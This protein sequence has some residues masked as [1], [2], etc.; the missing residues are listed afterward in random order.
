MLGS[1]R[2]ALF[3]PSRQTLREQRDDIQ[4]M[5]LLNQQGLGAISERERWSVRLRPLAISLRERGEAGA[6]KELQDAIEE[7]ERPPRR[8]IT[9]RRE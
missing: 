7:L 2:R 1:I 5:R 6:A 9:G 8:Q 3:G 4:R